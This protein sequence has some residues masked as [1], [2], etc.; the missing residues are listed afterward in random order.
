MD[1]NTSIFSLKRLIFP[2]VLFIP[3]DKILNVVDFPAPLGPKRPKTSPLL[4]IKL[5]SLTAAKPPGYTLF[6][7]LTLIGVFS[8]LTSKY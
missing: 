4:T 5:L 3:R 7:L 8:L 1:E 2:L 6:R